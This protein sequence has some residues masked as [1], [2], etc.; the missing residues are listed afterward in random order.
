[1]KETYNVFTA[2]L[3]VL[4]VK[5]TLSFANQ[6]FNEHPH[7]K[8]MYGLSKLLTDYGVENAATRVEDKE[9]D[10]YEIETPFV[11]QFSGD[12]VAVNKVDSENVSFLWKGSKHVLTAAKFIE[13]WTGIVLLAQ[14][15]DK[16]IEPDYKKH[17]KTEYIDLLKKTTLL[18]ACSFVALL[19]YIYQQHYI[20]VGLTL[21][22]LINI[23]GLYI[24]WLLLL[25]QMHV[26]NQYADKIC[27]LFKQSECNTVL[28]TEAA[29][30]WGIFG[31]SE[32]GFGYFLTNVW[33]LLFAPS[34][35]TYIALINL[36]T[37]PYTFWSVWYQKIKAHQWGCDIY[38][39]LFQK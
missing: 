4:E 12:F 25:K 1:M 22:L 37:L 28:E 10:I 20:N 39:M 13:A 35:I 9:K 30:L 38:M 6:S 18:S 31:W 7:K 29:K 17:R 33:I 19:G 34:W 32:I 16:S 11:A 24:S 14:T 2:F 3:D 8:N 27:S 21:L 23:A 15:S 5:H 26:G 36:L